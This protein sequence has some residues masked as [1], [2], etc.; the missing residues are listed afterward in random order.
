MGHYAYLFLFYDKYYK[1]IFVYGK[2]KMLH[3]NMQTN[4]VKL[5]FLT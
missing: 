2:F 4:E 3:K 1:F 5:Q